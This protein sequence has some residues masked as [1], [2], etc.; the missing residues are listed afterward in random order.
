MI[1]K[2]LLAI[3]VLAA[4]GIVVLWW[5]TRPLPV[6]TV[7]SWAGAYSQAQDRAMMRPFASARRVDTRLALWDGE[8]K[9]VA[10]AVQTGTYKGD[11]IDFELP[12]AIEACRRGL[13]EK[14]DPESLPPGDNGESAAKD[15][16]PGAIG[17]C[18]VGSIVYSQVIVAAPRRFDTPPATLA[19]FF[20]TQKFPGRRALS[21]ASP[22]FNLE[23]ALLADGIAPADV[24]KTLSTPE[25]LDRAFAKLAGLHPVWAHDSRDALEW[26]RNGQAVM[27]SALNGDVFDARKDFTPDVIWDR[28]MYELDVFAIPKGDPKKDRALDFIRFATGTAPLARTASWLPYGPAR[29]SA[30][31]RVGDNPELKIAM[32]P[33]QPTAH[34]ATAFAVD[35]GWWQG[36][37]AAL[38]PR[39]QAFVMAQDAQS[40]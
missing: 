9:D 18:W 38:M 13:L 11:V 1:R 30:W 12:R 4:A 37:M 3:A 35:D 26:V 17:P 31:S 23:M 5:F 6:L 40:P 34:F 28:Q 39:W 20:D 33:F 15:F 36:H 19:D 8:L 32:T 21:R 7:T 10:Q 24:Y 25:G 22:K 27:A 2:I 14:I 29:R 16:V